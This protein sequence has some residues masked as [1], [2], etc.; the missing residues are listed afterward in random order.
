M[1]AL[2]PTATFVS[3]RTQARGEPFAVRAVSISGDGSNRPKA[4]VRGERCNLWKLALS[5]VF[6]ETAFESK[7]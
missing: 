4:A 1:A 6:R 7:F 2:R 3:G 5:W